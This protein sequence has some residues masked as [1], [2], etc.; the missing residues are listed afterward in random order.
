MKVVIS[1]ANGF[2][3]RA[4]ARQLQ[5]S[6]EH[7][8]MGLQRRAEELGFPSVVVPSLGDEA[9][10]VKLLAGQ[11]VV[12]HCAAA[13]H[14]RVA[15]PQAMQEVNVELTLSL[16]R[17]AIRAGCRRFVFVSSIG[18]NGS[19]THD[20][21]FTESD[22]PQPNGPYAASKWAAEQALVAL[23]AQ[24]GLELVVVRPP[25]VY[26]WQAPGNFAALV[27]W[28]ARGRPLP[29]ARATTNRRSYVGIA[30]L[31]SFLALCAV[32]PLAAGQTFLVSDGEAISTAELVT[33]VAA[34]L[35]REPRLWPVPLPWMQYLAQ[36]VGRQEVAHRLFGNLEVDASKARTMLAWCPAMAMAH[37]LKTTLKSEG[38]D[39]EDA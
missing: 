33:T 22:T 17:A 30:N 10:L 3:G 16:A 11:E 4:V 6:A 21:P 8:V 20:R 28:I 26:S 7:H 1:G 14:R 23:A 37:Q 32:H 5:A 31:A 24:T 19:L 9:L 39:V 38:H 12:V 29:L 35:G 2:V 36:L 34:A 18:V 15:S 25:L 13:V 27:H